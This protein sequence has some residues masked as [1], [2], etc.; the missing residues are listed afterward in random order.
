MSKEHISATVDPEVK[1]YLS[2]DSVNTSGLIN[3]LIKSEMAGSDATRELLQMRKDQLESRL[4]ELNSQKEAVT[5]EL[6]M[7]D[8]QLEELDS[9]EESEREDKIERAVQALKP[10]TWLSSMPKRRQIPAVDSDEL[11]AVADELGIE[12]ETLRDRVVTHIQ[13]GE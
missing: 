13:E 5:Q 11:Q 2:R 3:Q 9:K 4:N 6:E 12:P 1:A 10:D 7:V 8:A